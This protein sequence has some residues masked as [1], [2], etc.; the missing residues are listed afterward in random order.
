MPIERTVNVDGSWVETATDPKSAKELY[1]K[2]A[3]AL[4]KRGADDFHKKYM[5]D[6]STG[7]QRVRDPSGKV[8]HVRADRVDAAL[9]SGYTAVGAPTMIVP[10][11]P[12]QSDR[13]PGERYEDYKARKR[14]ESGKET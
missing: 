2:H 13:Q 6:L 4:Q 9:A 8:T 1:D 5:Q 14:R 3:P 7:F 11:L 12:W 10:T